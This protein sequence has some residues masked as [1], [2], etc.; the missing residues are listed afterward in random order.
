MQ[1]TTEE[2]VAMTL[3]TEDKTCTDHL[4]TAPFLAL[5][6]SSP[7]ELI[8][9]CPRTR[10]ASLFSSFR[11]KP[12]ALFCPQSVL[13]A[14]ESRTKASTAQGPSSVLTPPSFL[15]GHLAA[16]SLLSSLP[17]T[18]VGVSCLTH[19]LLVTNCTWAHSVV[20]LHLYPLMWPTQL[21]DQGHTSP[22]SPHLATPTKGQQRICERQFAW[23]FPQG[24]EG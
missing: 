24:E 11:E 23:S 21:P 9:L 10:Q 8:S 7:Q 20:T 4:D 2:L 16:M 6:Q 3:L 22:Y 18:S 12:G 17:V 19:E 5:S 1:V 13:R 15:C 14:W